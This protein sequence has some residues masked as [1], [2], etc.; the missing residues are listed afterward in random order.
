MIAKSL[1]GSNAKNVL[2]RLLR[3]TTN[4]LAYSYVDITSY[5]L[6]A[7]FPADVVRTLSWSSAGV[8]IDSMGM[9]LT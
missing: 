2:D 6:V 3:N 7:N 4:V 5:A 9:H 8:T 1:S